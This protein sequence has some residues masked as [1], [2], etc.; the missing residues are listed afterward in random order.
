MFN[1]DDKREHYKI[2]NNKCENRKV[3]SGA[4]T[5]RPKTTT[6]KTQHKTGY[7]NMVPSQ[8]QW[9]TPASD[10]EPYQA[11]QQIQDRNTKHRM[12]TQLT[13]WPTLK[14]RKHKRT[15]VRTWQHPLHSSLSRS[16]NQTRAS[17]LLQKKLRMNRYL[18]RYIQSN[19]QKQLE[20]SVLL[21]GTL[22]DFSPSRLGERIGQ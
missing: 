20:L 10:W 18:N 15:M 9:Q 2:Q 16:S 3:L 8:R 22:T 1:I 5:Q 7:L 14:Q 21:K 13:S 17:I 19:L 4:M 6:H 11:K 12:P